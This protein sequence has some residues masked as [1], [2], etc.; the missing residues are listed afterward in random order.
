M[1][2]IFLDIVPD[3]ITFVATDTRKLVRYINSA[4]AP[5]VQGSFILPS[6]PANIIKNVFAKEEKLDITVDS[7]SASFKSD[8]INFTCRLIKGN[9]PDYNRVIPQ[10]NP[11]T[12]T[13]DR[14]SM[15]NAVRRVGVFVDPSHG[16][17]IPS[18]LRHHRTQSTGQ[19]FLYTRTRKDTLLIH[20]HRNGN[21]IQRQL[22]HR[23]FQHLED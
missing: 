16:G 15:I 4:G 5:G 23:H 2:G 19:Q 22:H 17:K 3:K 20:R 9:F 1:M 12:L 8:T 11:Y 10:S 21:R 14:M 6:K 7:K 13:V 18:H